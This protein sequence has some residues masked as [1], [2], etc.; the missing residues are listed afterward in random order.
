M[1]WNF[2]RFKVDTH[3]KVCIVLGSIFM[4]L[5]FILKIQICDN[6][7]FFLLGFFYTLFGIA[8]WMFECAVIRDCKAFF[9]VQFRKELDAYPKHKEFT[10]EENIKI[11]KQREYA[12]KDFFSKFQLCSIM[13]SIISY[14]LF[15]FTLFAVIFGPFY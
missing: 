14:L 8:S 13:L 4:F 2:F 12:E 9:R 10:K 11:V 6:F 7:T 3:Y 15:L 1:N 5:S